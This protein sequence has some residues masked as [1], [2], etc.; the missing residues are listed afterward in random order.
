MVAPSLRIPV[1]LDMA[2]F[3]DSINQA[4]S[5]TSMAT[6]FMVKEFAKNQLKLAVDSRE[7]KPAVQG[8]AKF[9]GDQFN[10]VKPIIQN[11]TRDSVRESTAAGLKIADALA[12]PAIKGSFQA[13]TSVGVP[14]AQGLA[15]ALLPIATRALAIYAAYELVSGAIGAARNQMA[16]MVAV[17]DKA[18]NLTVSPKFLQLFEAESRKLKVT[19]DELDE[20]LSNAFRA[21]KEKSPIDVSKWEAAGERITDVEL[22]LRVYNAELEKTGQRLEGLV[23]FRDA[24]TQ[25]QKIR[26]VLQSM[27]QLEQSGQRLA[28]LDVGER[29]FGAAFVDRIRQGK[30]SAESMLET[31]DRLAQSGSGIFQDDSVKRAKEIDDQLRLA[32]DRLSRALKPA[33]D[34]VASVIL[35][36][37][38]T[39]AD[40]VDLI[41]RA[42]E[43]V[44]SFTSGSANATGTAANAA[45]NGEEGPKR[46]YITGAGA[47]SRG[48]GAAPTLKSQPSSGSERDRFESAT[49]SAEK[50]I[51]GLK[52]E[53]D[54]INLTAEARAKAKLAAELETVAKQANAAA[55]LGAN[56]VTAEQRAKID[57]LSTSYGKLIA[58]IE[59]ANS[60]LATFAREAA[61][62]S[63]Q[64]NQAAATGLN[65]LTTALT[66]VITGTKSAGDAFKAFANT[67]V[68]ELVRIAVQKA[69]V[70]PI[71]SGLTGLF[72]FASGGEVGGKGPLPAFAGGG[73]VIS[74]PGTGT[75]DSILARVSNGEFIVNAQATARNRR[76][77]EAINAG[78]PGF[79][80]GGIV[81]VPNITAPKVG[82]DIY[83]D[84]RSYPT[85]Q[86]GMTPTD[87]AQIRSML[88]QNTQTT[89]AAVIGDLRRGLASDSRFLG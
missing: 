1:G 19:T 68:Q 79:A 40:V 6:D 18:A 24:Q 53:A 83:V 66:D 67:V 48:T 5:L 41:A 55:G 32:E 9:L 69:I 17:A 21:T 72:G 86:A 4:K 39:W 44:N 14:A 25:D 52:A 65:N 63:K 58:Q 87:M 42:V 80:N 89:R 46:V 77:L 73:G 57:E 35:T 62:V 51:A 33:W 74:G 11:V 23:L 20:A 28:A 76:L 61:D 60:P 10:A 49:E 27:V 43:L 36:I 34:S 12:A 47:P 15:A 50:R 2:G 31:M 54:A 71:A 29:M 37:K 81:G 85:F 88:D 30:T 70:G 8:A 7:F 75:S 56:V 38:S 22:A 82:G 26:A 59:Q 64:L 78:M 45:Q 13:F 16:D 3:K 84:A